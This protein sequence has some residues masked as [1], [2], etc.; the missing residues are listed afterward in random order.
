MNLADPFFVFD[1]ESI[2]LHG[3]GFAVGGGIYV[4]STALKEFKFCCLPE[5]AI[6][7]QADL[8][9]V[10]DNVPDMQPTHIFAKQVRDAFWME[11]EWARKRWPDIRMAGECVWPVEAGFLSK[12]IQDEIE[13]RKMDGP[14]PLLDIS[15]IMYAAGMDPM[16]T[17]D[18][19]SDEVPAHDPLND[20][21]Q[22]A[23]LLYMALSKLHD[24]CQG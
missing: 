9:W 2:G 22:S 3:E 5:E 16:A 15:S 19:L 11:W 4:S 18:R 12:C 10:M 23:R 24:S 8:E 1:V 17:Y 7:E 14:Y 20:A 21:R 6:G 13:I